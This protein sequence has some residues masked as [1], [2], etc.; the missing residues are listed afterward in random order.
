M[1]KYLGDE[2]TSLPVVF[3]GFYRLF[4]LNVLI[5]DFITQKVS[6][7]KEVRA[8]VRP[9]RTAALSKSDIPNGQSAG[10]DLIFGTSSGATDLSAL[11]PPPAHIFLL[12][13]IFLDN[14]R[15]VNRLS[16]SKELKVP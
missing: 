6:D 7:L 16:L 13:Q 15:V 8:P 11:H 5:D 10:H 14:V 1:W 12:W 3:R 4:W 9:E 2:V